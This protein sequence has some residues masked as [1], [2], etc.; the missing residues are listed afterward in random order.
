MKRNFFGRGG[1][2]GRPRPPLSRATRPRTSC[3]GPP[4]VSA[5][6]LSGGT[7]TST[8]R[9]SFRGVRPLVIQNPLV[10][11]PGVVEATH[12]YHDTGVVRYRS[13][14]RKAKNPVMALLGFPFNLVFA[15]WRKVVSGVLGVVALLTNWR[16]R[17]RSTEHEIIDVTEGENKRLWQNVQALRAEL[18]DKEQQLESLRTVNSVYAREKIPN[19]LKKVKSRDELINNYLKADQQGNMNVLVD[20]YNQLAERDQTIEFLTNASTTKRSTIEK[21]EGRLRHRE[22]ELVQ[23]REQV[24]DCSQDNQQLLLQIEA[25]DDLI[26]SL[27]AGK[28][29]ASEMEVLRKQ[30]WEKTK[31][32]EDLNRGIGLPPRDE[33]MRMLQKQVSD[34]EYIISTLRRR[35]EYSGSGSQALEVLFFPDDRARTNLHRL[36]EFINGA[37]KSLDI[38]VFTITCNDLAEA[39]IAAHQRGV[40]VRII[41]DDTQSQ[42]KGS[43]IQRI[44]ASGV[45]VKIDNSR[46]HMHHKFCIIDGKLLGNG[47]FNWSQQAVRY[48]QE[49]LII[50]DDRQL[51]DAFSEE[52]GRLWSSFD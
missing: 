15:A 52:F 36:V 19:L 14:R 41:S 1:G 47:S 43:D 30:V 4:R 38:C 35:L 20:L 50:Y 44:A 45:A 25:K 31:T 23:A 26:L 12:I 13:P 16:G 49:N 32:I 51:V 46:S 29:G 9:I 42:S 18:L 5:R 3:S 2:K 22:T 34:Q 33:Q 17:R 7:R 11:A 40:A 27:S 24:L 48:N 37:E 28:G 10:S 8:D 6:R 39:V 21:L